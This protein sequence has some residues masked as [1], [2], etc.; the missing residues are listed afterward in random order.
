VNPGAAPTWAVILLAAALLAGCGVDSED[1]PRPI[2]D[3]T[4]ETGTTPSV[5]TR[6]GPTP[7][8]PTSTP[9]SSPPSRATV[10]TTASGQSSGG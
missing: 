7:S 3:S 2:H 5:D 9:T 10:R 6:P 8:A 1:T 4:P